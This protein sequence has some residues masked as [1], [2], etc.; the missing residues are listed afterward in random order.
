MEVDKSS[1]ENSLDY[2]GNHNQFDHPDLSRSTLRDTNCK[3]WE[4]NLG[5]VACSEIEGDFDGSAHSGKKALTL[6]ILSPGHN[7][8]KV[9]T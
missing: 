1:L 6:W 4:G 8:L 3:D 7:G 9:V 2:S 5:S